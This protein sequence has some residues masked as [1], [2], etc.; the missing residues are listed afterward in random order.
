MALDSIL[1]IVA[2]FLLGFFLK[3][4][5]VLLPED[6][7]VFTRLIMNV[8]LPALLIHL[9][10]KIEL[11]PELLYFP[12]ASLII[13]IALL[14]FG[15]IFARLLGLK[16]KTR[17]AFV[18]AFPTMDAGNIGYPFMLVVFGT[19]GLSRMVLLDLANVLFLF[20]V[21]YPLAYSLGKGGISLHESVRKI[22]S[23]PIIW[24]IAGGFLLNIV[25]FESE[26]A[27]NFLG[28]I[29]GALLLLAMFFL[30]IEFEPKWANLRLPGL[31]IL[32]KTGTG[33]L[34]ALVVSAFFGFQGVDRMAVI[35]WAS[36]PASLLCAVF[37]KENKLDVEFTSTLLSIALPLGILIEIILSQFFV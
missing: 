16:E 34:L 36:L 4:R 21:V 9:F 25:G 12:L 18:T 3:K 30:G 20:F 10:W 7:K 15:F 8:V 1:P 14:I 35:I 24:G 28:I 11:Q 27:S 5:K 32:L 31:T 37:A 22:V 23:T 19:L 2:L 13:L 29:S 26:L 6:A 33:I 17:A